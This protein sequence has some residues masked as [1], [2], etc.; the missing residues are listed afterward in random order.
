MDYLSQTVWGSREEI[1]DGVRS[2]IVD[3]FL[4]GEFVGW[5]PREG[6]G[7]SVRE[8]Y[9]CDGLSIQEFRPEVWGNS[10]EFLSVVIQGSGC[11]RL[12]TRGCVGCWKGGSVERALVVWICSGRH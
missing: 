1:C 4:D 9:A 5:L 6:R 2:L 10:G 8:W 3:G 12:G 7:R 11:E